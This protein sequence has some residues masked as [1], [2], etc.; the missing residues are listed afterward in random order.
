[1]TFKFS[2][3]ASAFCQGPQSHVRA[4]VFSFFFF[5]LQ[6]HLFQ[7]GPE[8]RQRGEEWGGGGGGG[9]GGG[10]GGVRGLGGPGASWKDPPRICW[11]KSLHLDVIVLLLCWELPLPQRDQIS[12]SK[13]ATCQDTPPHLVSYFTETKRFPLH[14]W[15]MIILFTGSDKY[16]ARN[17]GDDEHEIK[18][19]QHQTIQQSVIAPQSAKWIIYMWT[20]SNANGSVWYLKLFFCFVLLCRIMFFGRLFFFLKKR[21]I[22]QFR[23]VNIWFGVE[24]MLSVVHHMDTWSG[25]CINTQSSKELTCRNIYQTLGCIPTLILS[26]FICIFLSTT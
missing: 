17:C 24:T 1:M 11:I 13:M 15:L 8:E 21:S 14:R 16:A 4:V 6:G 22:M 19:Q 23:Y 5:F 9:G 26:L 25:I 3:S 10:W 20:K 12:G 2:G 7:A 18:P